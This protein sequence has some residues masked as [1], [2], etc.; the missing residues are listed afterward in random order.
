[1]NKTSSYLLFV[2][3]GICVAAGIVYY[4][5]QRELNFYVVLNLLAGVAM[6]GVAGYFNL[7]DVS[8]LLKTAGTAD[9]RRLLLHTVL[10]LAL[11]VV[12]NLLSHALYFG[13]DL[14]REKVSRISPQ[15]EKIVKA[16]KDPIEI[17]VFSRGGGKDF[18]RFTLDSYTFVSRTVSYRFIDPE[19]N[20]Q[21][22]Q[23][24]GVSA[25]GQ[26]VVKLKE[27]SQLIPSVTEQNITNAIVRLTQN[28]KNNVYF[29]YGHG[30]HIVDDMSTKQGYGLLWKDL[31][32]ENFSVFKLKLEPPRYY[33]PGDCTILV[34][35]GPRKAFTEFEVAA[36]S[37]YL[38]NGGRAIFLLDP[39]VTTGLGGLLKEWNIQLED[40]CM[41][42]VTFPSIAERMMAAA[43]GRAAAPHTKMQVLVKDFPE[44]EITKDI[45]EQSVIMSVARSIVQ[46]DSTTFKTDLTFEPLARTSQWGWGET[47]LEPLFASGRVSGASSSNRGPKTVAV[48]AIKGPKDSSGRLIVIGDSDFVDNEYFNQLY[49]RDLFM[50]CMAYMAQQADMISVR[51]RHLFASRLDYDPKT[52]TR[53]F[54][55]TVLIFPQLLL[56]A[57]I[58]FWRLRR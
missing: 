30:E 16:L 12:V 7:K 10:V 56:M 45:R 47:D 50:N 21:L 9:S 57:G 43:T 6:L 14:T 54:T 11:L 39:A 41:V 42:D 34:I 18:V 13:R 36:I 46:A 3:G 19:K 32:N 8:S 51:P 20:P 1:M 58:A 31:L 40:D 37:E 17:L 52:M 28:V 49:N 24:Y 48:L 25:D 2:F 4:L 26:A 35:A 15:S 5:V 38:T 23:E 29:L 44:N 53:I 33:L 27:H 22:A 55:V